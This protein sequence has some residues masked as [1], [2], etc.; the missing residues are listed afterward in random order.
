MKSFIAALAVAP[1]IALAPTANAATPTPPP[2][3][4]IPAKF[5]ENQVNSIL[6][7]I[8]IAVGSTKQCEACL[9]PIDN[10]VSPVSPSPYTGWGVIGTVNG[11]TNIPAALLTPGDLNTK[12]G[13]AFM[14]VAVPV[15]NTWELIA[16]NRPAGGLRLTG[17]ESIEERIQK[18]LAVASADSIAIALQLALLPNTAINIAT[19]SAVRFGSSLSNGDSFITAL[20]E[21]R[22]EWQR[23]WNGVATSLTNKVQ[24]LRTDVYTEMSKDPGVADNPI[25]LQE[26]LAPAPPAPL[27]A[28]KAAAAV[29]AP[30]ELASGEKRAA[31][32]AAR[33]EKREAKAAARAEKRGNRSNA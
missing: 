22:A 28:V 5:I 10:G 9:G 11:I 29:G 1:A 16:V 18:T 14:A 7:A 19:E 32:A 13:N 21:G 30:K 26:P 31:R 20:N 15:W 33:A 2:I 3:G 8:P 6:A 4:A 12:L 24:K 27:A 23:A 17:P 25:P